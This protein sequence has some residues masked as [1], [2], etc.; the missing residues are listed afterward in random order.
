MSKAIILFLFIGLSG[1]LN[2]QINADI[3]LIPL[4]DKI[5]IP[6]SNFTKEIH[7]KRGVF[8]KSRTKL[9]EQAI[10]STKWYD[11]NC[12]KITYYDDRENTTITKGEIPDYLSAKI[13]KLD[14]DKKEEYRKGIERNQLRRDSVLIHRKTSKDFEIVFG[15][16]YSK[17]NMKNNE[18][19][20]VEGKGDFEGYFNLFF[21]LNRVFV[22]SRNDH[23]HYRIGIGAAR[24]YLSFYPLVTLE[25]AGI[26]N[27]ESIRIGEV[28]NWEYQVLV[29]MSIS[30][31]LP[32]LIK[33]G[34]GLRFFLG[35]E[36]RFRI[37][38]VKTQS[39]LVANY[40]FE[41]NR[42]DVYENEPITQKVNELYANFINPY[43]LQVNFGIGLLPPEIGSGGIK[44]T[45]LA[46]P[47][48]GKGQKINSQ[49]GLM[50]Y[51]EMP[52]FNLN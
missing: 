51:L 28:G 17:F 49:F 13:Y 9:I 16:H 37:H 23:L 22:S 50:V 42:G 30:Y 32:N 7:I 4:E 52:L 8:K 6:D 20:I 41:K 40:S 46:V 3:I 27:L 38:Q 33:K 24:E 5:T 44:L 21:H 34:F 19:F 12:L 26:S 36:H 15:V 10:D 48:F 29:P 14:E 43:S 11:G 47:S 35:M 45:H 25:N 39:L 1:V 2:G 31:E 18:G